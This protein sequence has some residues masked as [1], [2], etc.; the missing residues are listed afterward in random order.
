MSTASAVTPVTNCSPISH[1]PSVTSVIATGD[2]N[3]R[4]A[5]TM[6]SAIKEEPCSVMMDGMME[7]ANIPEVDESM[8][9]IALTSTSS[10]ESP[11]LASTSSLNQLIARQYKF[12]ESAREHKTIQFLSAMSQLAHMDHTLAEDIWLHFFPSVWRVL[13]EKQR[14]S[15]SNELVP[16]I[17]SGAH[18]I[19]RDCHPSA[20]NTFVEAV[21]RCQPAIEVGHIAGFF[22]FLEFCVGFLKIVRLSFKYDFGP[23]YRSD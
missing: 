5:F 13:N 21:S 15:L 11:Q 2:P 22:I 18:I 1:L 14:E 9:D 10:K 19:Q 20:L 16:F 23:L 17:C 7:T 12:L 3:E 6:L 8:E 4:N